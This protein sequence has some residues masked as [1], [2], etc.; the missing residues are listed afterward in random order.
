MADFEI[1]ES[2]VRSREDL[3]AFFEHD[4]DT[5]YF[6]LMEDPH[7]VS[8][9]E[10]ESRIIAHI[11]ILNGKPDFGQDDVAVEW[12]RTERRVGVFIKGQLWAA[13]DQFGGRY[14]GRYRPDEEPAISDDIVEEFKPL[15]N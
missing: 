1:Y 7:R 2:A 13:F 12:D 9:N 10:D 15:T 11:W 14:G 8:E 5:G 6:Y 4:G 3:G